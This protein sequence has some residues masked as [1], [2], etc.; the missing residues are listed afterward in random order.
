MTGLYA[1]ST[2]KLFSFNL[3]SFGATPGGIQGLL[4]DLHSEISLGGTQVI[5]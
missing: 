2:C 3:F 5:I 4:L 1:V